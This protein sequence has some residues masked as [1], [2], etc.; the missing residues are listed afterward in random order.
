MGLG[1]GSLVSVGGGTGSGGGGSAS[2]ITTINPGGNTGPT[3]DFQGVNGVSVT[4]PSTNII[5]IDGAGA[6]GVHKF[7]SDFVSITSGTFIHGFNS[8]DVVVQIYNDQSPRVA[9]FPD[10][11]QVEFN[12]VSVLFNRPQSG[13]VVI[14]G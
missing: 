11:I 1:V 9:I 2:G 5:L 10:E 14:I 4:S 6:S 12:F 13:R 7:A 3:V 8:Y